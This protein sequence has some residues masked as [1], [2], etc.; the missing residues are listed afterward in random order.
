M[1]V[2]WYYLQL[3]TYLRYLFWCMVFSNVCQYQKWFLSLQK[4]ITRCKSTGLIPHTQ[5]YYINVCIWPAVE[6]LESRS[7]QC[8]F[9]LLICIVLF[10]LHGFMYIWYFCKLP[11][12]FFTCVYCSSMIRPA[13]SF[14]PSPS[15][16]SLSFVFLPPTASR[17]S[18]HCLRS[19]SLLCLILKSG[20][21]PQC[22]SWAFCRHPP[23]PQLH[24]PPKDSGLPAGAGSDALL[25]SAL[26]RSTQSLLDLAQSLR[27]NALINKLLHFISV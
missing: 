3:L 9:V 6:W 4:I 20:A 17:S 16:S 13:R 27:R 10:N 24:P 23:P 25:Q 26:P 15:Q 21:F 2:N 11:K 5:N 8:K 19:V 12:Y 14:T 7:F 1:S 22:F 18:N